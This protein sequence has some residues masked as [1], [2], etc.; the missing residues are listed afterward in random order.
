MDR[1]DDVFLRCVAGFVCLLC[2]YAAV[3][4][5]YE[6]MPEAF[7]FTAFAIG[8]WLGIVLVPRPKV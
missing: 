8:L 7:L 2:I 5:A 3:M 4:A 1:G 6:L